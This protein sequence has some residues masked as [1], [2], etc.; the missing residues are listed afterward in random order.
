MA[1]KKINTDLQLEG[2][3]KV[4]STSILSTSRVLSNV[5][6]V[7]WDA[8]YADRNKWDGGSSG[9]TASTGRT[10][11]GLGTAATSASTDFVSSAGNDVITHATNQKGLGIFTKSAKYKI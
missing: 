3:L 10:S 8:A 4:G 6:N 7:N 11:L 5:T 1:I 2:E 9:I